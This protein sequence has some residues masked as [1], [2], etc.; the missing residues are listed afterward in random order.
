MFLKKEGGVH[1]RRHPILI[2]TR[3]RTRTYGTGFSGRLWPLKLLGGEWEGRGNARNQTQQNIITHIF[4][5]SSLLGFSPAS[6]FTANSEGDCS[7][8]FSF[9]GNRGKGIAGVS[10]ENVYNIVREAERG[11]ERIRPSR[12]M[13]RWQAR[14]LAS[15]R[16]HSR[17]VFG[18]Q[19]AYG[20]WQG[21]KRH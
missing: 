2:A 8:L 6:Y 21:G 12:Q 1:K 5:S 20:A 16:S 9:A 7:L 17:S 3:L 11:V 18:K 10:Q 14:R 19:I 13:T 15:K 4:F